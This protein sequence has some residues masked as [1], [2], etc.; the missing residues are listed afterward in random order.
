MRHIFISLYDA[1][2]SSDKMLN[3]KP[4]NDCIERHFKVRV[5]LHTI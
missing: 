1:Y 3:A 2:I 4:R 5:L